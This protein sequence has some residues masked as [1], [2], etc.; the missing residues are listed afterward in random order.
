MEAAA[1]PKNESLIAPAVG[2]GNRQVHKRELLRRFG[3]PMRVL[4]G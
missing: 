2:S 1:R 3:V 4:S